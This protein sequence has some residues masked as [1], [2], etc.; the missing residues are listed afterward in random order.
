MLVS[1]QD[2]CFHPSLK[3][4]GVVRVSA[5]LCRSLMIFFLFIFCGRS[6]LAY[7]IRIHAM[8]FTIRCRMPDATND[9]FA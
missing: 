9:V 3:Y 7:V 5:Y 1:R 6:C 8:G 2:E 4:R